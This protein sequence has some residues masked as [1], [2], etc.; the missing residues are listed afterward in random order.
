MCCQFCTHPTALLAVLLAHRLFESLDSLLK[1]PPGSEPQQAQQAQHAAQQQQAGAASGAAAAEEPQE[2]D[3]LELEMEDD[4]EG[5][6]GEGGSDAGAQEGRT[7]ALSC[8]FFVA[9]NRCWACLCPTRPLPDSAHTWHSACP[10]QI[11]RS[12]R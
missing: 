5:S 3:G 10:W 8:S 7:A 1:P 4:Q 12:W 11:Q 9:C 6:E 2:H